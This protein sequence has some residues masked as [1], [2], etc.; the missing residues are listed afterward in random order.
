M[1]NRILPLALLAAAAAPADFI[2]STVSLGGWVVDAKDGTQDGNFYQMERLN[3]AG[4]KEG[5][6]FNLSYAHSDLYERRP[7]A[8]AQANRLALANLNYALAPD[9]LRI[10]AGRDFVPLVD[11]A[12]YYDGGAARLQ[13]KG[14]RAELFGGYAVPDVYREDLVDLDADKAL[15][16][17]KLTWTPLRALQIHLD[18]LVNGRYDDGSMAAEIQARPH[19]RVTL[20][21]GAVY[22]RDSSG[23]SHA[24][25]AVLVRTRG[26]DEFHLRYGMENDRI[27][28]SRYYYYF[29]DR[30]HRFLS[31]GYSLFVNRKIQVSLDYGLT[32]YGDVTAHLVDARIH[33]YGI[34]L[35]AGK[36]WESVTDALNLG[37]G[38]EGFYYGR[39]RIAV[40]GGYSLY[41]LQDSKLD[42]TALDFSFR[43]GLALGRGFEVSAGY[44]F[45]HNRL[46]EADHRFFF[47]MK[48][49]FFK[50]LGK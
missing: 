28:S 42:L 14:V 47:G 29:V 10:A 19:G 2:K 18:G 50:G 38:Y 48:H 32:Y 27:D 40:D 5:M 20:T 26:E 21:G 3:V 24:D 35:S 36:E 8:Y 22:R 13:T 11:R 17:G 15:V 30:A 25:A 39:L 33:A 7:N 37:L 41:D 44:E 23:F 9:L 31:G 45:L 4:L 49:V 12:L 6:G 34:T 1:M 46:Y 43:P 16:G